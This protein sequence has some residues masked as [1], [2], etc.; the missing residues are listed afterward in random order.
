MKADG[1]FVAVTASYAKMQAD[2]NYIKE[3]TKSL[4]QALRVNT[5]EGNAVTL[6]SNGG[7]LG[8]KTGLY[9][10]ASRGRNIVDGKRKDVL[11]AKCKQRLEVNLTGTT[12]TL[13]SVQKDN[14]VAD[15]ITNPKMMN[16][17]KNYKESVAITASSYKEPPVV[18]NIRRLTP[19]E[20]ERLQGYSD[21]YTSQGKDPEG[22]IVKISDSQRYKLC[23]N[24]VTTNVIRA[25]AEKIKKLEE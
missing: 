7:G 3:V 18:N 16:H 6:S 19:V 25:I 17:K 9:C 14:M 13:T 22:N 10:V 21:N 5:T 1:T 23:G 11:G 15:F 8:A 4:P 12:N 24:S 2:A 20:C